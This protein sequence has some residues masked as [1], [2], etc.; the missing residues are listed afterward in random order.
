MHHPDPCLHLHVTT[1]SLVCSLFLWTLV[2][3]DQGPTLLQ[4]DLIST[5]CICTTPF[6]IRPESQIPGIRTSNH[7]NPH[8][9]CSPHFTDGEPGTQRGAATCCRAPDW[10]SIRV[11]FLTHPLGSQTQAFPLHYT[12]LWTLDVPSCLYLH[13][14]SHLS[15]KWANSVLERG[16]H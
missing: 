5:K 16:S 12:V 1:F 2:I 4:C 9:N 8:T 3:L 7:S 6:P 10:Q 13:C 14:S 11:G 15:Y